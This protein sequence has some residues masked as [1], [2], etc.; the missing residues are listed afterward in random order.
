MKNN[1]NL[2][3]KSI[4]CNLKN[5]KLSIDESEAVLSLF[6][7]AYEFNNISMNYIGTRRRTYV[8]TN[9]AIASVIRKNFILPLSD[10][11]E[12]F[13]KH[14]A[15]IVHYIKMNEDL[16]KQDPRH[17]E[18]F[19]D[20]THQAKAFVDKYRWALPEVNMDDSDKDAVIKR[21]RRDNGSLRLK[22][23]K[24]ESKISIISKVIA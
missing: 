21:L 4:E 11:G 9:M 1:M 3:T 8:E 5:T 15:T 17:L 16:I 2:I 7:H 12:I 18:L 14:H 10:I 19:E 24:L 23:S 6:K 22:M 13:N 20:L